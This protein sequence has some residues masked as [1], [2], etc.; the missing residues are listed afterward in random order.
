MD[1]KKNKMPRERENEL[2]VP[3]G[4]G[5]RRDAEWIY[6]CEEPFI[7]RFLFFWRNRE[8]EIYK[9]IFCYSFPSTIFRAWGNG[10]VFDFD[11]KDEERQTFLLLAKGQK[12]F[13]RKRLPSLCTRKSFDSATTN[14]LINLR[15]PTRQLVSTLCNL[16]L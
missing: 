13:R 2:T 9:D 11:R 4:R 6:R 7:I 8:P 10:S 16:T 12:V 14:L 15:L 5:G 1:E 3:L